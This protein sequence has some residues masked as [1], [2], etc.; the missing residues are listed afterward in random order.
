MRG[1]LATFPL[2]KNFLAHQK[3]MHD[4]YDRRTPVLVFLLTFLDVSSYQTK[5]TVNY[6]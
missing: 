2:P 1:Q 5:L 6:S 4:I 3:I